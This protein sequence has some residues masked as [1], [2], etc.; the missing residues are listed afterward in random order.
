MDALASLRFKLVLGGLAALTMRPIAT[1]GVASSVFCHSVC[2]CVSLLV[3]CVSL[4]E[5]AE[6]TEM[7]F[8]GSLGWAHGT[9]Y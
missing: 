2:R 4:V 8:T 5:T 7:P 1:D 3:T 9:M 6:R